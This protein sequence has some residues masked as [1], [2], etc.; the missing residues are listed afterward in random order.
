MYKHEATV[1]E[2]E[3]TPSSSRHAIVRELS[4]L[5]AF[6]PPTAELSDNTRSIINT[7]V[8]AVWCSVLS[9]RA[10]DPKVSSEASA[11]QLTTDDLRTDCTPNLIRTAASLQPGPLASS[12]DNCNSE[13]HALSSC[14]ICKGRGR[15]RRV[16]AD[17]PPHNLRNSNYRN[18][19]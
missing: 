2:A 8:M 18:S 5:I 3:F 11:T 6:P 13:Q 9:M 15:H 16:V 4:D 12:F 10:N 17:A 1:A 14:S 7:F 19:Y